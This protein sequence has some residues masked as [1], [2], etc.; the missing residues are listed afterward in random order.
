[1]TPLRLVVVTRR[2]WPQVSGMAVWLDNLSQEL[3]RLGIRVTV[4]TPRWQR[5]WPAELDDRGVRV[6]RPANAPHGGLGTFHYVRSLTRWLR[7]HQSH[8]DAFYVTGLGHELRASLAASAQRIPV[9]V[10]PE[11]VAEVRS[12]ASLRGSLFFRQW[13]SAA[14]YVAV[15]PLVSDS[16]RQ[17]GINAAR[18]HSIDIGVPPPPPRDE[19]RKQTARRELAEADP[20]LAVAA[21]AKLVLFTGELRPENDLESLVLAWREVAYRFPTARLWLVGAGP[22]RDALVTRIRGL[23][24]GG[25]VAL[26]GRFD[27]IVDFYQAAD[28]FVHPGPRETPSVSLIEAL[29]AGLPVIVAD[30]PGHRAVVGN[31]ALLVPPANLVALTQA[32]LDMLLSKRR[33]RQLGQAGYLAASERFS[34]SAVAAQ[35][36]ELLQSLVRQR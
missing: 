30:A 11:T 12:R 4:L 24:L 1:M 15:S 28:L 21:D 35:H 27:T 29:A 13:R 19:K 14:A 23:G 36:V 16:L 31:Q 22:Q 17:S 18:V 32:M 10:Q 6:I 9:V 34:L 20:Q 25:S 2:Y 33:A 3:H 26:V 8:C 7:N 5:D